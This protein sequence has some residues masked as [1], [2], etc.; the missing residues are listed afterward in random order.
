MSDHIELAKKLHRLVISSNV[1]EAVAAAK[2]L[3]ELVQRHGLRL[4]DLDAAIET[5]V[6]QDRIIYQ[7]RIVYRDRPDPVR[8]PK[9]PSR[10]WLD[11]RH[12]RIDDDMD[13]CLQQCSCGEWFTDASFYRHMD[14]VYYAQR[15][16]R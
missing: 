10:H 1:N 5:I 7:D 8:L 11:E 6:Y 2:K 4:S 12:Y 3:S 9:Q 16:A 14:T 13:S 15:H